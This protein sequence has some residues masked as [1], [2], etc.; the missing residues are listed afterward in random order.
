MFGGCVFQQ[1]VGIPVGTKFTPLLV[2]LK[3][4]KKCTMNNVS[5]K[6]EDTKGVIRSRV[7]KDRQYNGQE[8]RF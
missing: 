2:D 1:T 7:S 6:F 5:E 3:I 8:K 4:H